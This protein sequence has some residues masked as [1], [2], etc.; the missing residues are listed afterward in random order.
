MI[1]YISKLEKRNCCSLRPLQNL[2]P[3]SFSRLRLD[4]PSASTTRRRDSKTRMSG[5]QAQRTVARVIDQSFVSQLHL[6]S[7]QTGSTLLIKPCCGRLREFHIR[8]FMKRWLFFLKILF[9]QF[10]WML[11][12]LFTKNGAL[13]LTTTVKYYRRG[14]HHWM[15]SIQAFL[16]SFHFIDY[17]F[18]GVGASVFMQICKKNN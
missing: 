17:N 13:I 3:S 15:D 11:N 8:P 7:A 1:H 14:Q 2:S 10:E 6:R 18:W 16:P 5:D 12:S 9:K 4:R